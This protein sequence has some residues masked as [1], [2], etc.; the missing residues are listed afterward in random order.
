[1]MGFAAAA[2]HWDPSRFWAA[3][4]HEYWAGY[5]AWRDMNTVEDD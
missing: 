2:L 4:P 5:E 3:T 1:M